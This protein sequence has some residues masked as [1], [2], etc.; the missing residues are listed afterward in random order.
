MF[1]VIYLWNPLPTYCALCT[2]Y[3]TKFLF[4]NFRYYLKNLFTTVRT[5]EDNKTGFN[6]L[7]IFCFV[8]IIQMLNIAYNLTYNKST[9]TGFS[10]VI[11]YALFVTYTAL[12][13]MKAKGN[14]IPC[15]DQIPCTGPSSPCSWWENL[16]PKMI[17]YASQWRWH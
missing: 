2:L 9:W 7:V 14:S 1:L 15:Q 16:L 11:P 17:Q 8:F 5:T 3:I 6:I 13:I 10:Q 4:Q 12:C